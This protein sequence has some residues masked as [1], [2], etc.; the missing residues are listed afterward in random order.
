MLGYTVT[1]SGEETAFTI[2]NYYRPPQTPPTTPDTPPS[3][4]DTPPTT[5]DEP[6]TPTTPDTPSTPERSTTPTQQPYNIP[7]E[8]TPLAGLSQ[9]LGARRAAANSVLGA[10]RSPKTG[11]ASNAAAFAAA[12]QT[13][14]DL[15]ESFKVIKTGLGAGKREHE[16]P[17]IL[18]AIIIE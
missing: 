14:N 15:P 6:G 10:R 7:D 13:E 5:P 17:G 2:T 11:D 18:R 16:V 4:P 1:V 12:I 9:V 8:P 3:T